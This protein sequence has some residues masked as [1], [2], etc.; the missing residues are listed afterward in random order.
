MEI[1]NINAQNPAEKIITEALDVLREGGIVLYPTDTIYG[2]GVSINDENA[3]KKLYKIKKRSL[4]KPVSICVSKMNMISQVAYLDLNLKKMISPLLPGPFTI[5]LKKKPSVSSKI[6]AGTDKIGIRIP[7]I[8]LCQELS[9]EFPITST[10]ANISGK[11][12]KKSVND[13]E[14][15]LG[16]KVDLIL[17]SGPLKNVEPSTVIDFTTSPPKIL[18][19]GA[20]KYRK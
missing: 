4:D 15:Q 10:S 19:Q 20:G 16:A 8:P 14:I 13:I 7:D 5:I 17:N 11:T 18:R 3:L 2:L 9:R 12:P 1:I 6:T